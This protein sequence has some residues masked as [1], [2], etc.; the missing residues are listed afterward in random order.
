MLA[1]NP[2]VSQTQPLMHDM[3]VIF[4]RILAGCRACSCEDGGLHGSQRYSRVPVAEC[5]WG[6]DGAARD[7][8]CWMSTAQV[9]DGGGSRR[10][11]ANLVSSSSAKTMG[12]VPD[13]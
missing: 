11:L 7:R 10:T 13:C 1:G 12:P 9:T 3:R 4:I 5:G 8:V 6:V 2:S